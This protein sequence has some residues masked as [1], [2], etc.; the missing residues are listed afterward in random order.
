MNILIKCA[1]I[2]SNFRLG[3][4]GN[5]G[6]NNIA[7]YILS[8]VVVAFIGVIGMT[9]IGDVKTSATEDSTAYNS[10]AKVEE[11]GTKIFSWFPTIGT[12]VGGAVIIGILVGGFM[13][14]MRK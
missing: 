10:A 4:K 9:L 3:K 11:A 12:I 1:K 8:F 2:A 7:P 13:F 6:I 5:L 14:F